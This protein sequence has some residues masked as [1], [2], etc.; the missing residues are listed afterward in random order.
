MRWKWRGSQRRTKCCKLWVYVK[1]RE[2]VH[3]FVAKNY[4]VQRGV[5]DRGKR[6][7]VNVM[8]QVSK[9]GGK[10]DVRVGYYSAALISSS[11]SDAPV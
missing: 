7:L 10:I 2:I 1:A 4:R 3:I 9:E 11:S 6:S 5:G 8:V